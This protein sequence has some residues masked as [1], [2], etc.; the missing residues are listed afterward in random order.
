MSDFHFLRPLGLLLLLLLPLIPLVMRHRGQGQSGWSRIIPASLLAPLIGDA[1]AMTQ[2]QHRPGILLAILILVS[3]ISLA[4]PSW[5]E[6]PTPLQQQNDSLVIVL[7]MSLSML[8]TDVEPDRL[9]Q[10]KRKIRD[11]LSQREGSFTGL[12]VYAA[13]AHVV[14]PLTDDR[15]T[16]ESLLGVIDPLMMPASGNRA[17]LGVEK[18]KTLLEQG[19][20]GAG[21]I[22]L[23]SDGIRDE[24]PDGIRQALKGTGY[25]LNAITVGTEQG[26]PIPLPKR[27]FIRDQDKVVIAKADP[28]PMTQLAESLGGAGMKITLDD[29]DIRSLGLRA[30]DSDDWQK[31]DRE[32]SV[33][34]W[35]DDGYWLLW[36][37]LPLALLAW[38]RGA[39]L[40]VPLMLL[41]LIP[42][43][44]QAM[45]WDDLWSRPDQRGEQLIS[46]DPAAAADKFSDPQW[47]GSAL[48]RAGDFGT[49]TE[50]FSQV[51]TAEADYNRGNALAREGKLEAAIKAYDDAL[52]QQPDHADATFNRELVKKLLEQQK[53]QQQDDKDSQSQSDQQQ[54]GEGK[55][56]QDKS[57]SGKDQQGQQGQNGDQQQNDSQNQSSDGQEQQDSENPASSKGKNQQD[58]DSKSEQQ[59]QPQSG[60][61]QQADGERSDQQAQASGAEPLDTQPLSQS[62]EQWLRRIPDD[63]SGLMR[64]KFLLQYRERSNQQQAEGDTPW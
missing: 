40:L 10:A 23:V 44:A 2:K 37:M 25:S 19:A 50:R 26:G 13:D 20:P 8:A 12:V 32:L 60:Q 9:T 41:P 21:R 61:E 35:Q 22:L 36:L 31:S 51:D 58:E 42:Q 7:D 34:R 62:E 16:I 59:S 43:P 3:A 30:A 45:D 4:G 64:R 63:P 55:Q 1:D 5:R 48:Y 27:G 15:K 39:L 53:K 18:A 47:Q 54:N 52:A 33:Q 14:T 29:A 17:D 56:Q 38:R 6:A 57:K 28:R 46:A 11:I 49:A 24:D